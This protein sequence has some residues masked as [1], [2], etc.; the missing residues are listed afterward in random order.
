MVDDD[1]DPDDID[2]QNDDADED[3]VR[4]R[5]SDLKKVRTAARAAGAARKE[6]ASYK[7]QDT[8]RAAGIEGL[9]DRQIAVI[10]AQAE[11]DESPDNLKRIAQELGWYTPPAPSDE[12]RDT[13]AEIDAH[14][15]AVAA[16]SGAQPVAHRNT[17]PAEELASWPIDKLQRLDR[18]HPEIY[19]LAMR[20]EPVTLPAGFN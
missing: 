11:G 5:K 9:N 19:E 13:D 17:I 20:G 15:E 3:Y 7:R 16:T 8:V 4:I 18:N 10:A 12:E 6:L 14:S 1:F 2:V